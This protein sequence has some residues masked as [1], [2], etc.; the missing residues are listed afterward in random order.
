MTRAISNFDLEFLETLT[1]VSLDG[2]DLCKL[3]AL[4]VA[5]REDL[6]LLASIQS[7]F[8]RLRELIFDRRDYLYRQ[9][10]SK[11]AAVSAPRPQATRG[12]S[13]YDH[14]PIISKSPR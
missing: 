3:L 9:A 7:K 6:E 5:T 10:G 14:T 11:K 13:S 8:T 1:A 12:A 4:Q 2:D